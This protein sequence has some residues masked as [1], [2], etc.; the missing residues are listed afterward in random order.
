MGLSFGSKEGDKGS[1]S[2][3][4]RFNSKEVDYLTSA[5]NDLAKHEWKKHKHGVASGRGS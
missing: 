5:S 1:D 4:D 3:I 2:E